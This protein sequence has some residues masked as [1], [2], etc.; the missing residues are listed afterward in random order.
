MAH[1][2]PPPV[3]PVRRSSDQLVGWVVAAVVA[4]MLL[5]LFVVAVALS[6]A[7]NQGRVSRSDAVSSHERRGI[8]L[9]HHYVKA[10]SSTRATRTA[11]G[12]SPDSGTAKTAVCGPAP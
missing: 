8:V 11:R 4:G 9:A 10:A 3:H 1:P 12:S 6:A 2:W 5:F 7:A